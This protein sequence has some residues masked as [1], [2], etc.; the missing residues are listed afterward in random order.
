[1]SSEV[2]V[3]YYISHKPRLLKDFDK[4]ARSVGPVLTHYAGDQAEA[5][6]QEARREYEMLIPDLPYVGGRQPFTQF[7]IFTAWY[8]AMYR[9]LKAHGRTVEETGQ[10]AYQ[11]S[12]AFLQTY[13]RI[14]LRLLGSRR[15]SRRHIAEARRRAAESLSRPYPGD[16]VYTFVEGDGEHFD[17]GVDYTEC[18]AYEFLKSHGAGEL[19]QYLC[20]VDILY[21]D[22]F[23]WGLMRTSTLAEGYDCCDFRFKKGGR[24]QVAVP[25]AMREIV[26]QK[27]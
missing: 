14:V 12:H 4:A 10:I 20:P 25:E 2:S 1:M 16:W 18:G 26:A 21:S 19:A 11:V 15:F 23:G 3:G 7:L 6:I 24:T 5:L 22:A 17:W 13:P 9:V 8:L 27:R